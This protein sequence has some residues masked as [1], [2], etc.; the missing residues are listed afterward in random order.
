MFWYHYDHMRKRRSYL[1]NADNTRDIARVFK[2]PCRSFM[3][4]DDVD[5]MV[6]LIL[7]RNFEGGMVNG[8]LGDALGLLNGVIGSYIFKRYGFVCANQILEILYTSW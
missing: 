5:D 4:L 8:V 6:L 2:H 7:C 1:N 3:Y